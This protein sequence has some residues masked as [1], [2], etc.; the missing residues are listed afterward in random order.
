MVPRLLLVASA[1][2][3]RSRP[4]ATGIK[5]KLIDW[6]KRCGATMSE[7]VQYGRSGNQ[8]FM[9]GLAYKLV[10]SKIH[11]AIDPNPKP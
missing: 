1:R 2:S 3:F 6:A 7:N 11:G 10:L 8:P 9:Y 5:K 4:A